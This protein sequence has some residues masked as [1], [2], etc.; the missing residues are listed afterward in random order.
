MLRN[1]RVATR[2]P[3]Q[4]LER[5]RAFYSEKLGLEPAEEREGG[6]YVCAS[7]EFALFESAGSAAG[8]QPKGKQVEVPPGTK[9]SEPKVISETYAG[10]SRHG[11]A[12]RTEL[13]GFH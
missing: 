6:R 2:V 8:D 4:D 1:G 7:G 12:Q 11:S 5:A 10:V 13:V 9:L 3:A